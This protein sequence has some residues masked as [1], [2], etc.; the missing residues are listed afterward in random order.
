MNPIKEI[1]GEVQNY[2]W[3]KIGNNSIISKFHKDIKKD[4]PY[5]ELWLGTHKK[6]ESKVLINNEK[7]LLSKYLKMELPF[8]FKILSIR[9][10]LSI[11]VHPDKQT[12]EKLHKERP[13]IY[14]DDNHKPEMFFTLSGFEAL[15]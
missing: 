13:E 1:F 11:Q 10:A 6:A 7:I 8:L 3:G 12:A 9:K 5:A 4:L 2:N 15:C 14:V